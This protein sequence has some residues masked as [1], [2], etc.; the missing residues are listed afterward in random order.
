MKS[1]VFL[2]ITPC[3]PLQVD[4]C[5]RGTR[6]AVMLVSCLAYPLTP[7]LEA[8]CFSK[9]SVDCQRTTQSESESYVTTDG[10][11]AS[12]SW[13]KAPIWALRPD[14]YYCRTVAGLLMWGTLSDK[15]HYTVLY[16]R[17]YTLHCMVKSTNYGAHCARKLAADLNKKS[18]WLLLT[19]T[20]CNGRF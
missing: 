12:L 19:G 5:F 16:P 8:M 11:S 18:A 9:M 15:R 13:N 7:K 14:F 10:Q 4:R 6:S 20:R 2:D 17:R 3:S 1:S